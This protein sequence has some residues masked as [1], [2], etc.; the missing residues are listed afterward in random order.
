VFSA[1]QFAKAADSFQK[2]NNRPVTSI[3]HGFFIQTRILFRPVAFGLFLFGKNRKGI[4]IA[5]KA[6]GTL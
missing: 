5:S 3:R 6:G 1:E 4:E 2:G